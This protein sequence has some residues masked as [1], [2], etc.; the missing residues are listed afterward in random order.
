MFTFLVIL[1][2]LLFITVVIVAAINPHYSVFSTYELEHR[3]GLGDTAARHYLQQHRHAD[4][5]L[6]L[7]NLLVNIFLVAL[8]FLLVALFGW[9]LGGLWVVIILVVFHSFSRIRF[10]RTAADQLYRAVESRLFRFIENNGWLKAVI[11]SNGQV[12]QQFRIGSRDELEHLIDQSDAI[13]A[14]EDKRLVLQSLS[15]NK[16]TVADVMTPAQGIVH[17]KRNEFLGPLTLDELHK[18]G[19]SRLP[20]THA[21]IDHIVG[22]LHLDSLLTLDTKRSVTAEK[23][24]DAHVHYIRHDQTLPHALSALL[25]THQHMFIVI[26]QSRRTVGLVTIDDVV[27]A[28]IGR[29]IIDDFDGH[30]S[31]RAVAEH[32][33]YTNN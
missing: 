28:L 2:A 18:S 10:I 21:D 7:R 24:M 30:E 23:A 6:S 4:T 14:P 12:H 27:A 1:S 22:I 15:F 9:V 16:K 25:R 19:H 5:V 32:N 8:S 20:V 31:L 33:P 3:A 11:H 17:I 13:L 26:D 29:K